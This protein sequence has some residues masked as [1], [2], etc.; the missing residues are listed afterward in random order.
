M[1]LHQFPSYRHVRICNAC[2]SEVTFDNYQEFLK[3]TYNS[4]HAEGKIVEV[5][6]LVKGKPFDYDY[7]TVEGRYNFLFM[8]SSDM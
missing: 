3:Y 4:L 8:H 1:R 5:I 6:E 7:C 2:F